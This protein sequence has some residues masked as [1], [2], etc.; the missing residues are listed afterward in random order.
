MKNNT[1]IVRKYLN[2]LMDSI[3]YESLRKCNV[4]AGC[5]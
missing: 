5:M 2:L 1:V 4:L 3:S